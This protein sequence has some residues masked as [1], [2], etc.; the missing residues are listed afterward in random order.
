MSDICKICQNTKNIENSN[1]V[2]LVILDPY[3]VSTIEGSTQE[4]TK[5]AFDYLRTHNANDITK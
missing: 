3:Q 2:R 5:A 1:Q 4:N